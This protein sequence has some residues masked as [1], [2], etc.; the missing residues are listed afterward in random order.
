MTIN[1]TDQPYHWK[2]FIASFL[3]HN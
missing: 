3:L 1:Y 2:T